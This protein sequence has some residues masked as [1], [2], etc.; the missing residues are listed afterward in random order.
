M[1]EK[2]VKSAKKL[3]RHFKGVANHH[4]IEILLLI[5]RRPEIAQEDII[6]SLKGNQ[7]TISEHIRRLYHAGLI[8]KRYAGRQVQ[9]TLTPYGQTFVK[10]ITA[11][12]SS[13]TG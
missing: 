9:H 3:E 7:K 12:A 13:G 1:A 11:F 6:E 5:A 8:D 2:K 4:R 10:F